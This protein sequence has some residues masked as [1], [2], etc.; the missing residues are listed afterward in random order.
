MSNTILDQKILSILN[1]R[2]IYCPL[3]VRQ[4]ERTIVRRAFE[5]ELNEKGFVKFRRS[6]TFY[7]G[8][9]L[10]NARINLGEKLI[11]F[12]KRLSDVKKPRPKGRCFLS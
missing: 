9:S 10:T 3:D 1:E 7:G 6:N 12:S 2:K 4:G 11:N 5:D 8:F